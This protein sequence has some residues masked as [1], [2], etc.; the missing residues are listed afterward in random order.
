MLTEKETE[1]CDIPLS[2]KCFMES[3]NEKHNRKLVRRARKFTRI[4]LTEVDWKEICKKKKDSITVMVQLAWWYRIQNDRI[5]KK[6]YLRLCRDI[7]NLTTR[8]R[9][10]IWCQISTLIWIFH[11]KI[12]CKIGDSNRHFSCHDDIFWN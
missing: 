2:I 8:K 3:S 12:D 9:V 10:F 1:C 7:L 6:D 5:Q 11:I 4:I